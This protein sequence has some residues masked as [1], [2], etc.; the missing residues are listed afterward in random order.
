MNCIE[1][2]IDEIKDNLG[3]LFTDSY[4]NYFCQKLIMNASS[5]Q[6]FKILKYFA[7][8]FIDVSCH[9]VGTHSM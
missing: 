8:D 4:A 3:E 9:E 7:K 2:I 5:E 1:L 6:R